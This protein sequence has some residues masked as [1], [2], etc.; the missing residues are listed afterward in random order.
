MDAPVDP[1]I[2][3]AIGQI[4]GKGGSAASVIL[5]Y[6]GY[7]IF[8]AIVVFLADVKSY[9]DKFYYILDR[10]DRHVHPDNSRPRSTPALP[11]TIPI[12]Q[13]RSQ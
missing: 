13:R 7:R 8:R 4:L 3:D 1:Q 10:L 11:N 9:L 5:A 2:V 12:G 6:F